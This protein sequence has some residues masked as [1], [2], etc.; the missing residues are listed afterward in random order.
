MKL[1]DPILE[2]LLVR[3]EQDETGKLMRVV[4]NLILTCC[5]AAEAGITINVNAPSVID[6]E[7]F[8]RAVVDALNQSAN[9]GT[10]GGGGIR[11]SAA[12]L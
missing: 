3:A 2:E 11:T 10:G 8:S 4:Q 1:E 5:D 6:S 7:G 12:I 9:R